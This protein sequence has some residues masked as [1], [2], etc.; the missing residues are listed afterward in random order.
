METNPQPPK[1]ALPL[2]V[3]LALASALG[4]AVAVVLAGVTMLLA[5]PAYAG[6]EGVQE[7]GKLVLRSRAGEEV[8]APVLRT[9]VR[10]RV[11]GPVAR[12]RVVQS[13]RNPKDAWC[14]GVYLLPLPESGEVDRLLLKVGGRVV[15]GEIQELPNALA[16][17]VGNVGPGETVEIEVEYEQPLPYDK[18][19]FSLRVLRVAVD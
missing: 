4:V 1:P 8:W 3:L 19:R 15:E 13:F 2:I 11:S 18:G 6:E 9:E 16:T 5:A 14:D 17:R 10:F 7:G 12:A